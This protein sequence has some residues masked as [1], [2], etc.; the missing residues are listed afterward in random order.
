M[1]RQAE[2]VHFRVSLTPRQV[3]KPLPA[4]F[5]FAWTA[6]G[7][8]PLQGKAGP[9]ALSDRVTVGLQPGSATS[10]TSAAAP[11]SGR[12]RLFRPLGSAGLAILSTLLALGLWGLLGAS[13]ETP[14]K[15]T[16]RGVAG[17]L[18]ALVT[19]GSLYLLSRSV[20]AEGLA[21][22]ELALLGMALFAWLRRIAAGGSKLSWALWI[23]LGLSAGAALWCAA[24]SSLG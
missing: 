11:A 18:A 14:D 10:A 16:G 3:G 8:A 20:A 17:F 12:A 13:P 6:T 22:V 2:G 4:T 15:P 7:L 5:A 9:L 24:G 21:G 1:T 19:L 23:A